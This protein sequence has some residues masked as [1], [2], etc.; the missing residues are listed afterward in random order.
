M[1]KFVSSVSNLYDY[2]GGK[3]LSQLLPLFVAIA[4]SPSMLL[5]GD[6]DHSTGRIKPMTRPGRGS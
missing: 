6:E 2:W 4:L 1:K 5:A 3:R